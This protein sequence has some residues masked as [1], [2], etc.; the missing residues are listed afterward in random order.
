[1]SHKGLKRGMM[2]P[3]RKDTP[4]LNL[5]ARGSMVKALASGEPASR[6]DTLRKLHDEQLA[7]SGHNPR[8]SRWNTWVRLHRN[9]MGPSVPPLPL[10]LDSIAAVLGQLKRGQYRSAD[11]YMSVAKDHHLRHHEWS[12]MLGRQARVCVRSALRGIGPS[13]QCSEIPLDGFVRAAEELRDRPTLPVD[14]PG[15]EPWHISFA[16]ASWSLV[17]WWSAQSPRTMS[18]WWFTSSCLPPRWT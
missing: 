2:L 6:E 15:P 8:R 7:G 16:F 17:P 14:S 4:V 12:T 5:T 9:W 3:L 11:D 1:M 10:T 18:G 13:H